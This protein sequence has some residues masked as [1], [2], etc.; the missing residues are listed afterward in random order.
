M[1]RPVDHERR[2][3][4]LEAAG[5]YVIEYGLSD[6]SLRPLARKLGVTTTTLVHHFGSRDQLLASIIGQVR[7]RM[8]QAVDIQDA[9]ETNPYTLI[10]RAWKW[11]TDPRHA[12]L[13]RLLFEIYGNALQQPQTY[14]PFLAHIVA[15]WLRILT[16]A[17]EDGGDDHATATT[18][19]TLAIAT[20]RGLLL[21]LLTTGDADRIT[22]AFDTFERTLGS[23]DGT[24]ADR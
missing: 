12:P 16:T 22:T 3:R 17:F 18:K 11:L 5:D 13:Y 24:V 6:L 10:T 4:L 19:A 9:T 15:D 8:L 7:D 2:T 20:S 1:A 21:D 23:I 14:E